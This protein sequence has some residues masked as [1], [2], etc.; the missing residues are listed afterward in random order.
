MDVNVPRS[1]GAGHGE[2]QRQLTGVESEP[3]GRRGRCVGVFG[4]WN[5]GPDVHGGHADT[6]R[7]NSAR[8]AVLRSC[9]GG[10]T[11]VVS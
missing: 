4:C 9:K 1:V 11:K 6:A 2:H 8:R 5:Q 3:P 7:Q 10:I